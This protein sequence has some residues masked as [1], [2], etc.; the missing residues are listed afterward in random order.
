[1]PSIPED[2]DLIKHQLPYYD[3]KPSE[4]TTPAGAAVIRQLPDFTVDI[5]DYEGAVH[6]K[7][8]SIQRALGL[9]VNNDLSIIQNTFLE[10]EIN[11]IIPHWTAIVNN[12]GDYGPFLGEWLR[13]ALAMSKQYFGSITPS[14]IQQ[15]SDFIPREEVETREIRLFNAANTF[16]VTSAL[17]S[18]VSQPL[19]NLYAS[20][21]NAALTQHHLY[22]MVD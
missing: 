12:A 6:Q 4:V 18:A 5:L 19:G 8:L 17:V 1:L 9:L 20:V 2:R 13:K 21:L 16:A 10:D 14:L 3:L 22:T 11:F 7:R 15:T